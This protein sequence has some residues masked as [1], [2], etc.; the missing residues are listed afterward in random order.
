[1][2]HQVFS[3]NYKRGKQEE[4]QR[5][6]QAA[7][8]E[9][10]EEALDDQQERLDRGARQDY[11]TTLLSRGKGTL[12]DVTDDDAVTKFLEEQEGTYLDPFPDYLRE[13]GDA[14]I[15]GM[16]DVGANIENFIGTGTE[17]MQDFQP[18]LDKLTGMNQSAIDTLGSIYDGTMDEALMG[19]KDRSQDITRELQDLNL[20]SAD[21]IAGLQDNVLTEAE[22]YANSLGDS[23]D[24]EV[25]LANLKYDELDR[26]PEILRA[27]NREL[28]G[29]YGDTLQS[30]VD[31]ASTLMDSQYGAAEGILDSE[32]AGASGVLG[33]EYDA[34]GRLK[35]SRETAADKLLEAER[36]KALAAAS[37]VERTANARQ[38]ALRGSMVGQGSGTGENMANAMIRAELGQRRGD[39]LADAMI[40]DAQRRGEAGIDYADT[41]GQADITFADKMGQSG[42]DFASRLG[43]ADVGFADTTGRAGVDFRKK[44]ESLVDT[45]ADLAGAE[46]AAER[47]EALG[48]INPALADVYRNEAM[49]GRANTALDFGDPALRAEAENLGLDQSIVDSD[50]SLYTALMAQKLSNTDLIP[51]LGLQ[52]A[53]LP[54]LAG[55]AG[56]AGLGSLARNVSA[57]TS[58]G[59]LPAGQTAF[60]D[61][62]YVPATT[63]PTKS[64]NFLD[65]LSDIPGYVDK[66]RNAY[67]KIKGILDQ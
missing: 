5:K 58:T 61:N 17:R 36:L 62:A 6:A 9:A 20:R 44:F 23:V 48:E 8:D 12:F 29:K 1:M 30:E 33:S 40:R 57:Y 50:E 38:R 35:D 13:S 19:F 14:L 52:E 28:G 27:Q 51:G 7:A 64:K 60:D 2:A 24:T 4:A 42:T 15:E 59:T 25:A 55:E 46:I 34:A 63:A 22:K 49:L 18:T 32:V 31:A 56:L 11:A 37:N 21:S 10:R 67:N 16:E 45:D 3:S 41:T 53:T 65:I 47:F 66:G 43:A 54:A 39:L 26:I